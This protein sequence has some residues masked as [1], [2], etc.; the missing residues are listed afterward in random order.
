MILG[1]STVSQS[2]IEIDREQFDPYGT[3]QS[4]GFFSLKRAKRDG[5]NP[6]T[7]AR[8][9]RKYGISNLFTT[10]FAPLTTGTNTPIY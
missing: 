7:G 5:R 9:S 8:T 10:G 4:I 3:V 1:T 6:A 2:T